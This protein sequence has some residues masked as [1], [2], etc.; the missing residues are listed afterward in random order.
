[1]KYVTLLLFGCLTAITASC[2]N[3]VANTKIT[4]AN[5]TEVYALLTNDSLNTQIIDVRTPEECTETGIVSSAYQINWFDTDFAA[6]ASKL[7]KTKPVLIYCAGGVRSAQAAKKLELLG[8]EKIINCTDGFTDLE[9]VHLLI[10]K[11]K[12]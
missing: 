12:E 6:Q 5:A 8:F 10:K 7:D 1:M 9:K 11:M 4:H 2:Q 3:T